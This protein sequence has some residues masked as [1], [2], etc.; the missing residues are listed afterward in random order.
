M[1]TAFRL[2]GSLRVLSLVLV[3]L[4][5]AGCGA[6]AATAV[7][8][9]SQA[10][11]T[12]TPPPP[13]PTAVPPTP[14]PDRVILAGAP[15]EAAQAVLFELAAPSGLQVDARPELQPGDLTPAVKLAVLTAVPV[16]LD[17][18]IAA[19]PSTQ[20]VVIS[21]TPLANAAPNLTVI[22]SPRE[23]Q[24]FL[25]GFIAELISS[26]WRAA[27]L[28]PADEPLGPRLQG[29]FVSGGRYWCGRCTP[30]YPPLVLYPIYAAVPAGSPPAAWQAAVDGLNA[31]GLEVIYLS[32]EAYSPELAAYLGTLNLKIIADV[33]PP[34]GLE[35]SWA[36][37]VRA[38]PVES[39]KS[40]WNDLLA[41]QGGKTLSARL[42]VDHINPALLSEG[43]LRLVDEARQKIEDGLLQTQPEPVQ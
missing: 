2:P 22:L 39:L 35:A 31:K 14:E 17:Q 34:P 29:S 13:E 28:L 21:P 8:E 41:G 19:G 12:A 7:I 26:D 32:S 43:R 11:L 25:A 27:A 3:V 4:L 15:D 6:P 24:A 1:T 5:L 40:L 33:P 38:D 16:N 30:I 9:P 42:V 18:L 37:S 36:A 10:P 20:F 23:N